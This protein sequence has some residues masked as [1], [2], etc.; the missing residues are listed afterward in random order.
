MENYDEAEKYFLS[1]KEK[2]QSID[3]QNEAQKILT[4]YKDRLGLSGL[5]RLYK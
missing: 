5:Y 2:F 3:K 4:D 1:N